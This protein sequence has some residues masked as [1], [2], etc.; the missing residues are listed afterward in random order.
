VHPGLQ[1]I[2]L[3]G[4]LCLEML[5]LWEIIPLPASTLLKT[6]VPNETLQIVNNIS[7]TRHKKELGVTIYPFKTI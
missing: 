4:M 2:G 6:A 5:I 7:V 3:A 1:T